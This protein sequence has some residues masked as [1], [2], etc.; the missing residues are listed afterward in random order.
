V[1]DNSADPASVLD[2]NGDV[3]SQRVLDG[4]P[5]H[6]GCISILRFHDIDH[7]AGNKADYKKDNEA[8]KNNRGND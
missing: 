7:I 3:I 4:M 1:H 8:D 5:V 2:V 6:V